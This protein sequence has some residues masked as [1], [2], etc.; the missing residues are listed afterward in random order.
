M[1]TGS[2]LVTLLLICALAMSTTAV[3][4]AA[5]GH[6]D[7]V[8]RDHWAYQEIE[9]MAKGGLVQGYGAR[10]FGPDDAFTIAQMANIV[11]KTLGREGYTKDGYWAYGVL[12][13]CIN[14]IQCLP[15]HGAIKPA[16]YDVPVTRELALHMMINA[17]G[18]KNA[19][20]DPENLMWDDV[21][22]YESIEKVYRDSVMA[23]YCHH[24]TFGVDD[25]RTFNPKGTL[26]RA[27]GVAMLVRAGYTEPIPQSDDPNVRESILTW[28]KIKELGGWEE[29]HTSIDTFYT[30]FNIRFTDP[31]LGG[32]EVTYYLHLGAFEIML[33]EENYPALYNDRD[34]FIDVD[35]NVIEWPYNWDTYEYYASTGYSLEARRFCRDIVEIIVGEEA[36]EEFYSA[37]KGVFL[38]ERY[39]RGGGRPCGVLW[40]SNRYVELNNYMEHVFRVSLR[41]LNSRELYEKRLADRITSMKIRPTYY[42]GLENAIVAYD[43][44]QW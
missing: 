21:P 8:E 23:A 35:G 10:K 3:C 16:N 11:C 7:D 31:H 13:Y 29:Y 6:F 26:T 12:D 32:I 14:V 22:D 9:T 28:T 38:G 39:D 44:D 43:L 20:E 40:L 19:L 30:D 4:F 1:K 37:M 15:D 5:D 24:I 33:P 27:Q 2:R 18:I 25:K 36:A 41:E 42:F 17:L 34:E